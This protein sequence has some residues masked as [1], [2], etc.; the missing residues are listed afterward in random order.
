[1]QL[2]YFNRKK[3][4]TL[5]E[6][7]LVVIL[8]GVLA[9]LAIPNFGP[10]Y[11]NLQLRETAENISYLMRY[12]QSQSIIKDKIYRLVLENNATYWIEEGSGNAQ[13]PDQELNFERVR[14]RQGRI[15]RIPDNLSVESDV[16]L[17]QFYPDG[18][19]DKVRII[20]TNTRDKTYT[21]STAEQAGM[22]Y[23]F[24]ASIAP[25]PAF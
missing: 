24:D 9:A 8:L 2:L 6:L 17:I 13:N 20:L 10:T 16:S 21:L 11:A 23:V 19:I 25:N 22:V 1:M 14:S 12:A 4:F 7:L 3:S 5:I 18:T 15:F